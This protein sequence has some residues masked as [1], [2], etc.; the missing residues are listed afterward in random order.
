MNEHTDMT[1]MIGSRRSRS[2]LLRLWQEAPDLPWR[3]MLRCVTTKEEHF[4]PDLD[5]L[6]AFLQD[7]TRSPP[8]ARKGGAD[9]TVDD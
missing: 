4:F 1:P 6:L 9:H 5:R 2:Y 3:A 8:G 7:Q